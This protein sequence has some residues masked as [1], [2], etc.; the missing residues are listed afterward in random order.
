MGLTLF[1][2]F[3]L[4]K[5]FFFFCPNACKVLVFLP[6]R[7]AGSSRIVC[8]NTSRAASVKEPSWS[9]EAKLW[10]WRAS[11]LS[12]RF[13]PT[14]RTTCVSPE[15]RY[16]ER[17][18][19]SAFSYFKFMTS[20]NEMFFII[21]CYIAVDGASCC[22]TSSAEACWFSMFHVK[23]AK[24]PAM[25]R[26]FHDMD[27]NPSKVFPWNLLRLSKPFRHIWRKFLLEYNI[28]QHIWGQFYWNVHVS[29]S[30]DRLKTDFVILRINRRLTQLRTRQIS[31]KQ[32]KLKNVN[33]SF[34][35]TEHSDVIP[36]LW[37]GPADNEVQDHR[38]SDRA[39]QQLGLRFGRCCFH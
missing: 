6:N 23:T 5:C 34:P 25:G 4:F 32:S 16:E 33:M 10:A 2:F 1:N 35:I 13:S 7:S 38:G 29:E 24:C 14:W 22:I 19:P 21:I 9:V 26:C 28:Q 39:G 3:F 37:P 8:W 15:R 31:Q 27:I 12:Q 30:K 20:I 36:D 18:K 11:S 17:L